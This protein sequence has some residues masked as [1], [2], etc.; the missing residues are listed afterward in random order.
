L[1]GLVR[2]PEDARLLLRVW[3]HVPSKFRKPFA[4]EFE[5]DWGRSFHDLI[6]DL[7]ERYGQTPKSEPEDD[8]DSVPAPE[9]EAQYIGQ[10][11]KKDLP[12]AEAE[13][14]M[15]ILY[16]KLV[17][18]LHPDLQ[19]GIQDGPSALA[20]WHKK[21]WNRL[22]GS[23]EKRD[24]LDL[25]KIFHL[26]LIRSRD[27]TLLTISEIIQSRKWLEDEFADLTA[28]T[29]AMKKMPAWGFSRLKSQE[30]LERKLSKPINDEI[31]SLEN[32]VISMKQDQKHLEVLSRVESQPRRKRSKKR[33]R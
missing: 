7:T 23:Y 6:D 20:A 15:K 4:K 11:R 19:N 31:R 17:R 9:P 21:I 33:Q 26:V 2:T 8:E 12:P 29:K 1:L 3:S 25:E 5:A 18:R 30:K 27:L 28:Q 16:R 24:H 14:A 13:E 10:P 32:E 22:Q